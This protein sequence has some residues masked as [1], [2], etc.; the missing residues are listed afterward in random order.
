M[1]TDQ[2]LLRTRVAKFISSELSIPFLMVPVPLYLALLPA[3]PQFLSPLPSSPL[4]L[5]DPVF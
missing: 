4:K 1:Q 2:L 5:T 3:S